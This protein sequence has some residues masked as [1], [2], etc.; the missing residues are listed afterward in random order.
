MRDQNNVGSDIMDRAGLMCLGLLLLSP[1]V[2]KVRLAGDVVLHPFTPLLAAA[3]GWTVWAALDAARRRHNPVSVKWNILTPPVLLMALIILG[4]GCSL[5]INSMRTGS[6]QPAGW[7]LLVKWFL[8]LAPLPFT[9]LLA[10]RSGLRVMRLLNWMIPSVALLTLVYTLYRFAQNPAASNMNARSESEARYFAMGTFGEV[11]S[12]EGLILR[13]DTVAQGAYGMYL[14]LVMAFTIA[15]ALWRGMDA[16]LPRW[17]TRGQA[18]LVCP[19]ALLGILYT[20]SRSSLVLLSGVVVIGT[21]LLLKRGGVVW[22]QGRVVGLVVFSIIAS[23]GFWSIRQHLPVSFPAIDRLEDT[24]KSQFELQRSALG[25]FSP[26][27][28]EPRKAVV[29]NVESRVWIWGRT[30]RYLKE[31]PTALLIGIGND[32]KQFLEEVVGLSYNGD[33]VHFQTAHNLF[34]DVLIKGGVGTLALLVAACFRLVR[35]AAG[36]VKTVVIDA[37]S[38]A[39]VGIG[40]VLVSFWPPFMLVNLIGEEMFTDNLQLHW[41]M[42]F[43]LLLGFLNWVSSAEKS[44]R[45]RP[46]SDDP[47]STLHLGAATGQGRNPMLRTRNY[48]PIKASFHV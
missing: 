26:V 23:A 12:S 39:L 10:V 16:G 24:L 27:T 28:N 31:H 13:T 35:L 34:L 29:R 40:L 7:L 32:R 17:Y 42:L 2:F 20:G 33:H 25:T 15:L 41:T 38:S 11:F 21:L 43:G 30:V 36:A 18:V 6:W 19:A 44:G 48:A 37:Q 4:L 3:W 47:R 14:V 8:Y 1:L 22:S 9:A 46:V 5:A 45:T